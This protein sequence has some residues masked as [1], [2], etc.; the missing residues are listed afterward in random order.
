MTARKYSGSIA[1]KNL[2][3]LIL[4]FSKNRIS[5]NFQFPQVRL[6]EPEAVP[7]ECEWHYNHSGE[8]RPDSFPACN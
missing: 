7:P 3:S 1:R 2:V 8:C 5:R 6:N 4:L